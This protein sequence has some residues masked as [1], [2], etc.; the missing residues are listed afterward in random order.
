MFRIELFVDDKN[1][2]DALRRLAGIGRD[3]RAIP[4][5]NAEPAGRAGVAATSSGDIVELFRGWLTRHK[6]A[7]ISADDAR[8]FLREIGRSPNSRNYLLKQ[9]VNA[10]L[11]RRTGKG[12]ASRYVVN[13]R[14]ALHRSRGTKE[15]PRS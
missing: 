5:V 3:V 11:L 9:A 13:G 8:T 1:L 4:V 12:N 14:E 6:K 7:E 10:G 2:A 15:G